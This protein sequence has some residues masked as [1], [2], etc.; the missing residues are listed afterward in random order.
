[1]KVTLEYT[2]FGNKAKQCHFKKEIDFGVHC[3]N[4]SNKHFVER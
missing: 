2:Y 1:M 4:L 3:I